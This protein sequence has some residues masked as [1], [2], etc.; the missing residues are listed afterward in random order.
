MI[1]TRIANLL[2]FKMNPIFDL[3]P[4]TT[5][6]FPCGCMFV[7]GIASSKFTHHFRPNLLTFF[8]ISN[9]AQMFLYIIC[10][11]SMFC[12]M[13]CGPRGQQKLH[14]HIALWIAVFSNCYRYFVSLLLR[15][16]FFM[17]VLFDSYSVYSASRVQRICDPDVVAGSNGRWHCGL[18]P[19][20][21]NWRIYCCTSTHIHRKHAIANVSINVYNRCSSDCLLFCVTRNEGVLLWILTKINCAKSCMTTKIGRKSLE[22]VM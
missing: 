22:T 3:Y 18:L 1:L 9:C 21:S 19:L 8:V 17:N 12:T 2:N 5:N 11:A 14:T 6:V 13:C 20:Q 10:P 4:C 7:R 15:H 16:S